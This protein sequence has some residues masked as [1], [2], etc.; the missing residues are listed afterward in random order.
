MT[1][2]PYEAEDALQQLVAEHPE[3]LPGDDAG[4]EGQRWLLID[5]E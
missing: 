4:P 3:M 1:E 2:T 5:R